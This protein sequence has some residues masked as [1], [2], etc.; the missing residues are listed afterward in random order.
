[1]C[2]I[3]RWDWAG[4]RDYDLVVGGAGARRARGRVAA[5]S[6]DDGTVPRHEPPS[7]PRRHG[8]H[9]EDLMDRGLY[10]VNKSHVY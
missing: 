10:P 8:S 3:W 9:S 5:S 1:M 7:D 4:A 2:V 6:S